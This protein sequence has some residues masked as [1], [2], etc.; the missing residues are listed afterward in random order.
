MLDRLRRLF[1]ISTPTVKRS[2]DAAAGGRRWKDTSGM[3]SLTA[4]QMAGNATVRRRAQHYAIN[5]PWC[6]RATQ[7]LRS[8]LVGAGIKPQSRHPAAEARKAIHE[9]W[10]LWTAQADAAGVTDFYGLQ[11]MVAGAMVQSGEA[12]VRIRV[13]RP[14]D[15]LAVPFQLQLLDAEQIDSSLHRDLAGGAYI[16]SGIEFNAL[17]QRTAYHITRERPGDPLAVSFTPTRVPADE[18]LHIYQPLVP[19]QVRGLAWFAPILLRAHDLDAF[20]DAELMKAKIQALFA[21]FITR[22]DDSEEFGGE[23]SPDSDGIAEVTWEPGTMQMLRPGEDVKFSDPTKGGVEFDAFVKTQLRAIAAGLGITYEQLTGD[24]TGVNYSSARV[25]LIEFRRFVEQVQEQVL[26][27]QLCRPVWE[28]FV[29][30]AV[31]SGALEAPSFPGDPRPWLSVKWV[32]PGWDWV[33]PLKDIKAEREAVDAGFKSRSEVIA[34]RGWDPEMVDA[35]IAAD[36]ARA[37]RLG[38]KLGATATTPP[39]MEEDEEN[40]TEDALGNG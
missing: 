24:M 17:G 37:E 28:R 4:A 30:L 19:G 32:T 25:A 9:L 35:E 5:S 20:E 22:P 39:N 1:R 31:L 14:D 13:R 3:A 34:A 33:D 21:G 40:E 36:A 7:V 8:N 26:V 10:D 6:R 16:R 38:L 15:G 11:A 27:H 18:V 23:S 2:L 12:F 29:R